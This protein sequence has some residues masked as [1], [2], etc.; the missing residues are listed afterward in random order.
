[1]KG[2]AEASFPVAQW[3]SAGFVDSSFTTAPAPFWYGDPRTGGT[4]LTDMQGGYSCIFLRHTFVVTNTAEIGALDLNAFIDDGFIAWINGAEV[5]RV[6]MPAGDPTYETLANYDSG[7]ADPAVVLSYSLPAPSGYLV[8]G[9][10]V[11]AVQAFNTSL[12][13]SSDF[14]FDCSLEAT[15]TETTPPV[16]S[17]VMPAAGTVSSLTS[18]QVTFSEPVTGVDSTDLRLNGGPAY[19]LSGGDDTYTFLFVQP[20]EGIVTASW[21]P[22]HGITDLAAS[23]NSFDGSGTWQYTLVDTE[24]PVVSLLFPADGATIASLGQIE[25][26]FNETVLGVQASD[27]LINGAPATGVTKLP[28]QPY[29]FSFPEPPSGFGLGGLGPGARDHGRRGVAERLCRRGLELHPGPEP[30]VGSRDHRDPGR[31]CGT[32]YLDEDGEYQDWIEIYNRGTQTVD[33]TDW[34]LSDD[35]AIPGLWPFP[36]RSLGPGEYLVVFAS[37]K[38][39]KPVLGELHTIFKLSV[40]GEH[41]GLYTP[42]SPR[43]LASGFVEYPEQR[44][45]VSYGFDPGDQLRYFATPTPGA[46]NGASTIV[47]VVEPLHV[48]VER[49]YFMNSFDLIL[50]CDTP[51]ATLRYTTDGSEPTT[52]SPIFPGTLTISDLT[53]FRAVGFMADHLPTRTITHSYLFN[54]PDEIRSLPIVSIVTDQQTSRGRMASW[55]W[56]T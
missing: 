26:T 37:G 56:P 3:R 46:A 16:V 2:T 47:G 29:V 45:D 35:P 43:V 23:S 36:A 24:P 41:L 7:A 5:E 49:G 33:L 8:P 21:D 39:R 53:L 30:A 51:G 38:D 28:E 55:I 34:S 48:N 40:G 14:G 27:L 17:N 50:S 4:Q 32:G 6:S 15:I 54:L 1:M 10:N 25:V 42:D 20:A 22:G 9:T 44:N 12:N 13:G 19:G 52:S 18:V 11:L 31:Q